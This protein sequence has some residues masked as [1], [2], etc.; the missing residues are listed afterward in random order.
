[1]YIPRKFRRDKTHY[2]DAEEKREIERMNHERMK[3]EMQILNIRKESY[4]KE[5]E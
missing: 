2:R 1:M 3:S 5:I 4:L